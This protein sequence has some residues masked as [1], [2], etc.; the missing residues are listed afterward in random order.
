M[1]E[2]AA[3]LSDEVI[4][5]KDLFLDSR[6]T[7]ESSKI[8]FLEKQLL[9]EVLQDSD[10][11]IAKASKILGMSE[12]ILQYKLAKYDIQAVPKD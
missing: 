3:I 9:C 5:P 10:N 6:K 1:I 11:D 4:T 2:R 8:E 7:R 12:E